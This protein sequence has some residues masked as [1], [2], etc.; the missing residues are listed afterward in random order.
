MVVGLEVVLADGRVDHAPA[1]PRG[2]RRPRP[3]P[4][5]RRQRG[6]ARRHHRRPAA[7]APRA[8]RPSGGPPTASTPSPTASTPAAGSSSGA[9]RPAVLRLYDATEADRTY[10]HRRPRR[11]AR[12]RRGRPRAGRRRRWR[13]WPRSARRRRAASTT[14]WSSHWLEHRNDVSALEAL[15]RRG[16]VVDTMEVAG[17]WAALPRHLRATPS[18]ALGGVEGTLARQRPPVAQL[19]RRR[20]PLLHVRRPGRRPSGGTPTTGRCGTPAPRA[21]LAARRRAQ[22]PPRRRPQPGPVR[23]PRRSGGAFDVLVGRQGRARPARHPEPRQARPA[24]PVRR[25]ALADER[26]ARSRLERRRRSL[27][28]AV[29]ARRRSPCPPALLGVLASDDDGDGRL[30][31][32]SSSSAGRR[33]WASSSA[34]SWPA[35]GQPARPA[36]PRRRSPRCVGLSP[37]SQVVGVVRHLLGDDDRWSRRV[38]DRLRRAA[39]QPHR[40]ASAA[41]VGQLARRRPR[42]TAATDRWRSDGADE[43]PRRRRRHER[44]A[45]R[46]RPPRRHR[47]RRAPPGGAARLARARARRVRR[48]GH[49]RRRA[50]GAPGA[51]L[52]DG[53]PGRRGRHRQPAGV[54]DRVGPRHRRAGRP[55]PRLAGPAHRRRLPRA[56]GRG[57]P[58]RPQRVG[59]QGRAPARPGRP[60]P[61]PRPAASAPSTRGSRGRCPRARSTSPTSTNAGVTGLLHARRHRAGTT[62]VLDALRIPEPVAARRSS[63]RP[64][65]SARPRALPTARRRSPASPAT[66]RRRWSARAACGPGMAKITFGTG[67]MLDLVP[68]ARAARRS[69]RRGDGGTF[70]IV[71]WRRDGERHV[72][73]RGGH[74][75]GRHQRRVAARRPRPDRRRRPSPHERGRAVR[76][77]PTASWYVPALLGLGTPHWDYG[78][79]GTLLGITRGTGPR[80]RSCGPCSRASP[81]GAPTWSRRPRPTAGC[82]DRRACGSTAA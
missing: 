8:R 46:G 77:T 14:A 55:R 27:A 53:R 79:R 34:G 41:I 44:R 60:R 19:H 43:P 73:R 20:L 75:L 31:L 15:I 22:P 5:V 38:C 82:T 63:T 50:R 49:G 54:D 32:G 39:G 48:R 80:R 16:F 6:H 23:A 52:A 24:Q 74:A 2:G 3:Q 81:T 70:P 10:Q 56:A 59:H 17:R 21:V 42:L 72:G 69:R 18:T 76:P 64:A 30:G 67:G 45:G 61:Q 66:S 12:A 51:A 47:R 9:P 58:P 29:V 28:G 13:S 37:S 4:A 40:H 62:D 71:A 35:R 11:A 68:R 25:G 33:R 36:R 1:A 65:S 26:R 7:A 78:A 57:H